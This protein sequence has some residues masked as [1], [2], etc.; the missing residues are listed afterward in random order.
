MGG[1]PTSGTSTPKSIGL[2]RTT[3][4]KLR[5]NT[6][7]C[8]PGSSGWCAARSVS[9]RRTTCTI[10]SLGCSSIAMN[11]GEPYETG[12]TPLRHL[13]ILQHW[14]DDAGGGTLSDLPAA[15]LHR[16][17]DRKYAAGAW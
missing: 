17:W 3:P 15:S 1:V 9:P 4:R 6:L 14:H 12:S 13:R 7:I 2:A 16:A 10:W 5:A 8:G 11:L